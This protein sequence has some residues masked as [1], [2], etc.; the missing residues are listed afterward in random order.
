MSCYRFSDRS[1]L[2][3][4]LGAPDPTAGPSADLDHRWFIDESQVCFL[5][6]SYLAQSSSM[7]QLHSLFSKV[8]QLHY[9]L[10]TKVLLTISSCSQVR[11]MLRCRDENGPRL[12]NLITD[13]FLTLP[14]P[15]SSRSLSA[16]Y[17]PPSLSEKCQQLWDQLGQFRLV[18]NRLIWLWIWVSKFST[19]G[20]LWVCVVLNPYADRKQKSRW[21]QMLQG[22]I[23]QPNCPPENAVATFGGSFTRGKLWARVVFFFIV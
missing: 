22:W 15:G 3:S 13:Q 14:W 6:R 7:D 19:T 20:A 11:D 16:S 17:H 23:A 10:K 21:Q 5:V 9:T 1:I 2:K 12:L 8:C 4:I 18:V